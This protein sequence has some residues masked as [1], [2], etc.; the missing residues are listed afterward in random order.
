[1][2]LAFCS[3]EYDY[4]RAVPFVQAVIVEV[5]AISCFIEYLEW[6]GLVDAKHADKYMQHV[7]E[8]GVGIDRQLTKLD[9]LCSAVEFAWYEDSHYQP[10]INKLTLLLHLFLGTIGFV[11]TGSHT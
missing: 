2:F 10:R 8:L 11:Y 5:I 4:G 3:E 6:E 9:R 1:M 7:E